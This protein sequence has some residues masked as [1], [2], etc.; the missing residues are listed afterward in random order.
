MAIKKNDV[1]DVLT[2]GVKFL[3]DFFA[4]KESIETKS[5]EP[6]VKRATKGDKKTAS[7]IQKGKST[8]K[9]GRK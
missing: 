1:F 9:R 2:V 7:K 8:R 3:E 4:A 5:I 6:L